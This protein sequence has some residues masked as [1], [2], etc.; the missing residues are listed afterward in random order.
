MHFTRLRYIYLQLTCSKHKPVLCMLCPYQYH[1]HPLFLLFTF[2]LFAIAPYLQSS[3]KI[4][5]LSSQQFEFES[6]E[7]NGTELTVTV[8]KTAFLHIASSHAHPHSDPIPKP[9]PKQE[10]RNLFLLLLVTVTRSQAV[11]SQR[12]EVFL[13]QFRKQLAT[14][15]PSAL[16]SSFLSSCCS[17]R[18]YYAQVF[19]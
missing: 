4:V 14:L 18:V 15:L 9:N 17:I 12:A 5:V 3:H 11:L 7:T 10:T 19:Y 1:S 13:V 16:S 8:N 2:T 6:E